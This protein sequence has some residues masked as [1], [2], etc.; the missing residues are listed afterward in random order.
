MT[1][2]AIIDACALYPFG[3]RDTLLALAERE[4][5]DVLWSDRILDEM[6]RHLVGDGRM[7][8]QQMLRTVGAMSGAFPDASVSREAVDRLEPKMTND[9][10]DRHVLAAA[11]AGR[12]DAV[13]TMNLRD[14]AAEHCDVWRV[15]AIHPDEF[16]LTL[17]AKDP[18]TT[19]ACL[20]HQARILKRPPTTFEK[21]LDGLSRTV[22]RFV[23]AVRG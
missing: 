17:L 5:Y 18:T 22:P 12:A 11:V 8:E 14:F 20:R 3:V 9:P 13:I 19:I 1:Y 2:R 4:F 7:T 16:L 15:R 6:G 21:H 10:K 23:A